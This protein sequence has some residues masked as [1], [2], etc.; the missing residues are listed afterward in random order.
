[1]NLSKQQPEASSQPDN[2]NYACAHHI[3]D[4]HVHITICMQVIYID[5]YNY[6]Y[7]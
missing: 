2:Y 3:I 5:V 7:L 1:M 6:E 4:L